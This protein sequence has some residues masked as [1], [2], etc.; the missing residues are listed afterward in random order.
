[1][2][3]YRDT[4]FLPRT[5]F[6]M[7]ANLREREPQI[8]KFWQEKKIYERMREKRKGRE[9]F[10][11]HVGPPYANGHIHVGHAFN[12]ILKD[13]IARMQ[14]LLGKDTPLI[15]GWDCHGLPIEWKI[16]EAC[17]AKGQSREEMSIADFRTQCRAFA[18]RWVDVQREEFKRLGL[19]WDWEYPYITMDY[20]AEADTV[21]KLLEFLE[22]GALYKGVKPVLWS[23]VEKT[24]LAEAEVEYQDKTSTFVYVRFPLVASSLSSPVSSSDSSAFA[25]SSIV[26]WTTTPWTLPGN[27]A[28]AYG[29]DIRYG[30]YR[31]D[32]VLEESGAR[33][34]EKL[35][36]ATTLASSFAENVG[37]EKFTLITEFRGVDLAGS[38]AQHPLHQQGYDFKVPLIAGDHV[39]TEAGT[40]FVHTAP[41]HGVEDFEVCRIHGIAVPETVAEDGTYYP[42]VP[43]FAG[44]HIFKADKAILE[45][46]EC[47]R[48]LVKAGTMVHSY[49]HSWRSKAPLI[50]RA[51]PQW[52]I[53]ME[54]TGLRQ[55]ALMAIEKVRWIPP[56]GENRIRGMVETRPDWCI[57]RQRAWGVPIA[58]FVDKRTGQPLNDP[59][60]N[61]RI[62]EAIRAK[63][64]DAWF[65]TPPEHF[66]G[67]ERSPQDFEQVRDILDVWFDAGASQYFV[68]EKRPEMKLPASL[69]LEGSDQHRGWFQSSLLIGCGTRGKAPYEAVL[70][71]G[72]VVDE[73]GRKMS[74]SMGNV[75]APEKIVDTLGADILRLWVVSGDFLDDLRIGTSILKHQEDIYRRYRNT[76]RYLLGSL[77]G[78]SKTEIL[79]EEQMPELERWM[80]HRL[81]QLQQAFLCAAETYEVQGFY[82]ALHTFCAV[83]LSAL[84]FDIRKDVLYCDGASSVRRR[85]TRTV[86]DRIF[87]ALV[88]WLSPVL[89]FTAEEAWQARY[90]GQEEREQR[91]EREGMQ[92]RERK[93]SRN[94]ESLQLST[95]PEFPETWLNPE[96][97]R[98]F[99]TVREQRRVITGALEQARA[100]GLIGS[101]LQAEVTLYD[102]ENKCVTD[103]DLTEL[104][105]VSKV[106]IVCGEIPSSAYQLPDIPDL[107]VV[108][109]QAPGEKCQRCW[110][111][112][113]DVGQQRHPD[114]CQRC[115]D[116]VGCDPEFNSASRSQAEG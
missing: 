90:R 103:M 55:K 12:F 18:M 110:R 10:I 39:T 4:I 5:S 109:Q 58:L 61:Q 84:Y 15:P 66:L 74:K 115:D 83:D 9:K 49:P 11:L 27:R 92:E 94:S 111:V 19:L 25:D 102:P 50:Y 82:A 33:K 72:F 26:I 112:L 105:I 104:A 35:V 80:L 106:R 24:A 71:H 37:I 2:S 91:Q 20:D 51:T 101:S 48:A 60:V 81:C 64:A 63:G 28:I 77:A 87:N 59:E 113:E 108:V 1:M 76:L 57:S 75:I 78:F 114:I 65:E 43:L 14:Q 56:Q 29:P 41:G 69:Y 46:L 8:L 7:K 17:R 16:E 107:G 86:M 34:G 93:D 30:L 22:N 68:L 38:E 79:P 98:K 47:A 73:Q 85:A 88:H 23:V 45:A 89:C 96:L 100:Q 70:T 31:V 3:D 44:Q 62:V 42:T 21:E 54:K 36:I 67:S 13:V 97:A 52:F 32:E 116:V 40:G 95:L 6:A 53:S 99:E